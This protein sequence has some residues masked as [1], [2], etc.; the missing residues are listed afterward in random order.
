MYINIPV[1]K[2]TCVST[3]REM[4]GRSRSRLSKASLSCASAFCTC[5]FW[6][7]PSCRAS[8]GATTSCTTDGSGS[9]CGA[10]PPDCC[11]PSAALL[12]PR[13]SEPP[14]SYAPWPIAEDEPPP[15]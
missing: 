3:S 14:A 9:G 4:E 12:V 5:L 1:Y 13:G 8:T 7:T 11:G 10:P 2:Y 6:C 15:V